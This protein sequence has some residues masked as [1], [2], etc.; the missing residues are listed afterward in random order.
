MRTRAPIGAVASARNVDVRDVQELAVLVGLPAAERGLLRE[1]G[2]VR[3][4]VARGTAVDLVA[5]VLAQFGAAGVP[6][7]A[8]DT[9]ILAHSLE[10]TPA[11]RAGLDTLLEHSL[12]ALARPPLI[13]GG[14]P[15]SV[16]HLG[17]ELAARLRGNECTAVV[18]GVD[19]A[20]THD[21]R[22]FF[23]SAMGDAAVGLVLGGEPHFG[24]LLGVRSETHVVAALGAASSPADVTR[25]RAENPTAIRAILENT[26]ADAGFGWEDLAAIIP[27]TPYGLIWDAVADLCRYPRE[28][29]LDGQRSETGHLNSNDVL[30]H[31][32]TATQSGDIAHGDIVALVSP[33]FGGTRGCALLGYDPRARTGA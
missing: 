29:I 4:P 2:L 17:I 21:A 8:C 33:G 12:P 22:F 13:V 19:V 30:H 27:H 11:D 5:D 24:S 9:V 16:I 15:C 25:F 18:L 3:I 7:A 23:G 31:L 26:L 28:R 1:N 10:L 32:A 6:A 14:R 20:P